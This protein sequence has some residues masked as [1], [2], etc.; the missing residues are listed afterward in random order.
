MVGSLSGL[1]IVPVADISCKSVYTFLV[2]KHLE[3]PHCVQKFALEFGSLYW[4]HTWD[5]LFWFSIDR[6]VIDLSW[7][8]AHGA[9]RTA[10]RLVSWGLNV[11]PTCFC[12]PVNETLS[13][14]FFLCPLAQSV[15][16]WL[17]FLMFRSSPLCPSLICRYVLFGFNCDELRCVPHVFSYILNVCKYFLWLARNYFRFR[18]ITPSA[19][20]VLESVKVCVRFNLPLFFKRFRSS[21]RR[22]YFVRQ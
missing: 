8:V 21:C 14:L 1:T 17:Q 6:A 2:S 3:E 13:H 12:G 5:Q 19:V 16:S 15:L 9:L 11:P 7:Q 20:D 22:R 18:G 4:P 10:D